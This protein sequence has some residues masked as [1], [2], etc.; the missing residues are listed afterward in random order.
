MQT[1]L[2]YPDF[3]MSARVLDRQRSG[4]QRVEVFQ[5]LNAIDGKTRGWANHPAAVMWRGHE[6]ALAEYG[7]VVCRDWIARGYKDTM[8]PRL[9]AIRDEKIMESGLVMPPWLGDP[10]FHLSHQSNLVRKLPEFYSPLFPGVPDNLPYIWPTT[11]GGTHEQIQDSGKSRTSGLLA[12]S[13]SG[14]R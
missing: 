7:V 6:A 12:G 2:A 5:L 11:T 1:F 3:A 10:E 14:L 8:L 4:K 13:T 9:E